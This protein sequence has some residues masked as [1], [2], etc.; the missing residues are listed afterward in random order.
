M[1]QAHRMF[2]TGKKVL[3]FLFIMALLVI[4]LFYAYENAQASSISA[5]EKLDQEF[6][7]E[8]ENATDLLYYDVLVVFDS[9]EN[10]SMLSAFDRDVKSF[11]HLPIARVLLSKSEI[12]EVTQWDEVRFV[13]P[14]RKMTTFNA[15]GREMTNSEQVQQDLGYAGKGVE[16][17]IIDTGTDG[18]H[19]DVQDNMLHNWQVVGTLF[20]NQT[21]Y[22][23]ST[24]DG[25]DVQT[26]VVDVEQ[27]AGVPVNTDEY[28]HGTHV[29]GTIAGSGAASEGHYR[30]MAPEANVHSYSASAGIFL[31]FVVEAYD[32]ILDQ[33]KKEESDIR[34]VS[35][36]WGSEGCEFNANSA[37]NIATYAAY[38]EGIL[39]VFAY[40][41]SGPDTNTCNPYSTAPYVLGIGAT[42]KVY[43]ITGFSSRGKEDGN[44]DREAALANYE[45]YLAATTEEQAAWD[46]EAKPMG[47]HRPSVSAP[48]ANI[49]S[50][51]NP[52]HPMTTSGTF[53]GSASGT[54]MAT[55]MVTGVLA[56]VIDAYQQNN[57]GQL[58]PIDL[59][60]L[61]EVTANK[62][63]MEGYQT[64]DTGAGFVDAQAAVE[65]AVNND[66]PT[67]VTENDLVTFKLPENLTVDSGAYEGRVSANTWQTNEGYGTHT[68]EVKEGALKAYADLSWALEAENLYISL[69]AP[70]ADVTDTSAATAQSAGLID[71]SNSRFVDVTFPEPGTWTIRI[72]GRNNL[73]TEYDGKWEV[74]YMANATPE[75]EL[76]VTPEMISGKETVAVYATILDA[77]GVEDITSATLNVRA[78]NG[79]VLY[80]WE[81]ESFTARTA[82]TLEFR[83]EDLKMTGKAP[84]TFTLTV[85]DS[86]G[87]KAFKQVLV[88]K[89]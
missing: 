1:I 67:Q 78:S 7:T 77:D 5:T 43:K 35:N 45:E 13:E 49:V 66:I 39:S 30:G 33:V 25:I 14:N 74:S 48:G 9:K 47:L 21:G 50:A 11:K 55:P 76:H 23:S 3:G 16:V 8:L 79:K 36:S 27:E 28:G 60:R 17:A 34:L 42:D 31:V 15:E 80:S 75:A 26:S 52:G 46:H 6:S 22:V 65:R 62:D 40:G 87:N 69:Y 56:L 19:P 61:T 12:K 59:I 51:Q 32:H 41:N 73:V 58:T 83:T 70:G 4:P 29:Y 20:T 57:D 68:F 38:K 71:L 63:I 72:D 53:Y 18:F 88:G 81:K 82:N 37:V 24:A 86:N 54:S 10:V 44:F 64:H 84:W 85:E 89:K 2:G